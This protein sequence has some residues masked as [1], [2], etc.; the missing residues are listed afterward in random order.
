MNGMTIKI[1]LN[2]KSSGKPTPDN[3]K[4]IEEPM[5][6]QEDGDILIKMYSGNIVGSFEKIRD[7]FP[8]LSKSDN[9]GKQ[10]VN[11]F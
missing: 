2:S 10:L 5:P 1:V 8:G 3:F 6:Y 9:I 11:F 7:A 4:F